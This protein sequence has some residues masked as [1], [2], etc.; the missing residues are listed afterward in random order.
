M[1]NALRLLRCTPS[2]APMPVDLHAE[3]IQVR[4]ELLAMG[5]LVEERV[6][7]AVEAMVRL[8]VAEAQRIRDADAEIDRMELQIEE[9]CMRLLALAQPVA[10]DLR[11]ILTVLR[12]NGELER[13]ADLAKGIS[14]RVIRLGRQHAV[15]I[16]EIS[17]EMGKRARAM[18]AEVLSALSDQDPQRCR[19][20]SEPEDQV[21]RLQKQVLE[22]VRS[23]V[24]ADPEQA[25]AVIDV[26]TLSQR[27]ERIADMVTHIAD[28]VIFLVEGRVVRHGKL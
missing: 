4:R 3:L 2:N 24:A 26:L 17:I 21:D 12:V 10:G 19:N 16:P 11:F 27:I 1:S 20:L 7:G 18:L 23:R 13:I 22:W 15:A 14:K 6:A 5:S 9:E 25:P 28:D 8:D